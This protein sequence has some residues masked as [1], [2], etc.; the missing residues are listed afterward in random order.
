MADRNPHRPRLSLHRLYLDR[1]T[2]WRAEED[3]ALCDFGALSGGNSAGG[4]L[5]GRAP[6]DASIRLD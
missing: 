1:P 5:C 2:N 4:F 3:A 6:H